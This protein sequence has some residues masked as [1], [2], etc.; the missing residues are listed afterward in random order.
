MLCNSATSVLMQ[1]GRALISSTINNKQVNARVIFDSASQRSF[2]SNELKSALALKSI[3]KRTLRVSRFMD[4]EVS[5]DHQVVHN[6]DLVQVRVK[7]LDD[8]EV[9]VRA[10]SVPQIC[11]PQ[12][13]NTSDFARTIFHICLDCN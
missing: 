6:C 4:A 13:R 10:C 12:T 8:S 1:T 5:N 2:I 9:L 11:P 7:G 3:G